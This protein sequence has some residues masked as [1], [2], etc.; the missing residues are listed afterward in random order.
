MGTSPDYPRLSNALSQVAGYC[1]P[2][3]VP[4]GA[5]TNG[6]QIVAFVATRVD[7]SPALDG[8]ALVFASPSIMLAHFLDLWQALSRYGVEENRLKFRLIGGL[9]DLPRKLSATINKYPGLKLRNT[10]QTDLQILSEIVIEDLTRSPELEPEFLKECYCQSGA[11]SQYALTSKAVLAA[12]YAALFDSSESGPTTVP[13]TTKSGTSPELLAVGLARR[14]ILLLGD[15]GVGKTTFIRHLISIEAAAVFDSAIALH[16]D[17]GLKATL[18]T[19]LR[20]FVIEEI[21]SQLRTLHGVDI[22]E[23]NFV[24]GIYNLD[25]KRFAGG[26]FG[27][28]KSSNSEKYLEREI[29]F[30]E[31]LLKQKPAHL[32]RALDHIS[33][34][35]RKQIVLFLDNADQRDERTQE[36]VFLMAQ[37]F[38]ESWPVMVFVALRPET[39]YRSK[40]VGALTAYHSKAFTISPPRMDLV[41]EK[42][43]KFALK[44]TSGEIPIP[45]LNTIG[46]KLENLPKIISI[47]LYSFVNDDRLMEF[48][49]NI[50]AGNV[51]LALDFIKAFIGSGHIDTQKMLD[52]LEESGFYTVPV[53][54]FLRAVIYGDHEYYDPSASVIANIFDLSFKDGKEH[55]LLALAIAALHQWT[56]A[57]VK[58]GFVE[59]DKVYERLQG[60]GFTP[61]Q[62]D[63]AIARA[64]EKGLIETSARRIPEPG[65]QMP[66]S[67][68]ATTKGVYHVERLA[69]EFQYLDAVAVDTPI[70][71]QA[72]RIAIRDAR[73]LEE[74]L[75]RAEEFAT[76][77]DQQWLPLEGLAMGFDWCE[78]SKQLRENIAR[79][80]RA[81]ER[82]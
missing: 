16:L 5:V 63:A 10:L 62:I 18:S 79:I 44:I 37:E 3:G 82:Y 23:R 41:I 56:G 17:L 28:L 77:F 1:Q 71:D 76:Y 24:R 81:R 78:A 74:R 70:L 2:R 20:L 75:Q 15:V 13:A 60:F 80:R 9:P 46:I 22:Y 52:I 39:F 47:L 32:K 19:D 64:C 50:S 72:Y 6:H 40:K 66:S 55:F 35:R 59:T 73:T 11:L 69:R 58:D 49:D 33:K 67:L 36:Q 53:H 54:E 42:R 51:R 68:R 29:E 45:S 31:G 65:Q 48:I 14:P 43:L 57:D 30:L 61:D 7:G 4:Y 26:V 38:A 34:G 12:R 25:L 27:D 8:K 21:E